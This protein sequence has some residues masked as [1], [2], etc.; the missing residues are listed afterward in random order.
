MDPGGLGALIG[1]SIM[2]TVSV[3]IYIYDKCMVK[4]QPNT[5]N[6]LLIRKKPFKMKNLFTHIEF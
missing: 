3:G 1:V 4:E 6:P 2:I 5:R